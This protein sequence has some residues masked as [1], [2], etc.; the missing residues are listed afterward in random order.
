M[1]NKNRTWMIVLVVSLFVAMCI[2]ANAIF[3]KKPEPSM[4]L[5]HKP[6]PCVQAVIVYAALAEKPSAKNVLL[7]GGSVGEF[8]DIFVRAGLECAAE[9]GSDPV[10]MV[11][12]AGGLQPKVS[13]AAKKQLKKD[14]LWAEYVNAREMSLAVFRETL[15]SVPGKSVH[16]WMPG[17]LDWLITGRAE[18]TDPN[19]DEML[20]LF[21]REGGFP[22]LVGAKCDSLPILFASFVGTKADVLPAFKGQDRTQK[23]RPEYFVP[24]EV[25][26]FDWI[27]VDDVDADI[28]DSALHEMRSMQVVRRILLT[29]V[30]QAEQ[31]EE[32]LS[33]ET[34]A[35]VALRSPC[36]TM[37]VERLDRLSVNAQAFL[38]LGKTA[39]AARCYDTMAQITPNDPMPVYNY[40]LCMRQLGEKEIAELAF[41]RAEDLGKAK[42]Q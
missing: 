39:M 26:K 9:G 30:M 41:K 21:A 15:K 1:K 22:D 34:W 16:L 38:K 2:V 32:D 5:E 40:G 3:G 35:K 13:R 33:V 28:R 27:A 24:R 29:G 12:V 36:D 10:D 7:L 20:G 6:L 18:G 17:E 4:R 31:G 42:E 14:G 37:L 19:L 11:F 8:R 23:V 25:P